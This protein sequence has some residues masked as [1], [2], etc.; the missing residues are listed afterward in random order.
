MTS[1]EIHKLLH[2][3]VEASAKDIVQEAF[4]NLVCQPQGIEY[5]DDDGT[6]HKQS[7]VDRFRDCV[8]DVQEALKTAERI[9]DD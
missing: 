8:D 2:D 5:K 6:T 4:K 7:A 3:A 1:G 9:I